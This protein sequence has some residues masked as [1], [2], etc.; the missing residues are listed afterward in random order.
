MQPKIQHL[1]SLITF[2]SNL[3]MYT[4]DLSQK[5]KNENTGR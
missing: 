1:L 3:L 5:G 4:S 2:W